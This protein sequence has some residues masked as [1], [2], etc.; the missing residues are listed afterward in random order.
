MAGFKLVTDLEP[1]ACL[2][3][4]WR[5]AQDAGFR[6][7]AIENWSFHAKRGNVVLS[8]IAGPIAPHC[9]FKIS[10]HR[11][12]DGTTDVVLEKN[13]P[14]LTSGRIGVN[15]VQAQAEEL[16]DKIETALREQG[17]KIVS[18]KEI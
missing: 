8:A 2:Q 3:I 17:G 10:A 16:A 18:R 13:S 12:E 5:T 11:Y 6:L 1:D 7:T 15:R 14:W 4:A 9:N